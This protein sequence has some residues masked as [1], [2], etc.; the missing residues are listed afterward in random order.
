MKNVIE[1]QIS[2]F[3]IINNIKIEQDKPIKVG[4]KVKIKYGWHLEKCVA[5]NDYVYGTVLD[6]LD[7]GWIKAKVFINGKEDV[8]S[9]P[10]CLANKI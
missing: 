1:G 7:N 3:D 9:C 10:S 8:L 4:I 2:V 6:S 5:V